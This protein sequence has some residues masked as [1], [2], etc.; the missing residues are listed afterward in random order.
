L[1]EEVTKERD[2]HFN[3]I[4][5]VIL[6]KQEWREKEKTDVP[7]PTASDDGMDMLDDNEPLLIKD[8]SLPLTDMYINMV[9][10]LPTEFRG[11]EE[12]VTQMFL[13]PKEVMFEKPKESSH[14]LKPLYVWGHIDR[15]P[16]SRMLVD[17]GAIVNLMSYSIFKK[18]GREDHELV[19]TNLM[20]NGVGA[21][22][23]KPKAS[24]PWS[25]L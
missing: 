4:R 21:T 6:T 5:S 13:G 8:G 7:A 15:K 24:S 25:S 11:N 2:E 1:R 12:K 14:H 23:W 17:D 16:I 18:L 20:L 9:F 3:T 10:T 19:K 22:R